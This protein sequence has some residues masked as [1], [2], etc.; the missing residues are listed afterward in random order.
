LDSGS[1]LPRA[2]Q[3]PGPDIVY[4]NAGTPEGVVTAIVG[5]LCLDIT[6][7]VLY[8]KDTGSGNT[9]WILYASGSGTSVVGHGC[10]V[11]HNVN[12]S[13][14]TSVTLY[15]AFNS[16]NW[17]T[18]NYHDPVT[19]NSRITIPT[20]EG[21]RYLIQGEVSWASNV[22][23]YRGLQILKNGSVTLSNMNQAPPG[24]SVMGMRI[25]VVASLVDGDYVELL[26]FQTS[27]GN[28]NSE[29]NATYSPSFSAVRLT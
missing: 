24:S 19:N 18:N 29:A 8:V 16:E 21:G 5:S 9:G 2:N 17:D 7:R 20:G 11:Y 10:S 15:H 14:T 22:I 4:K 26:G 28:L 25:S 1:L 12:Q 13:A 6:N 27:G 3:T 23:G